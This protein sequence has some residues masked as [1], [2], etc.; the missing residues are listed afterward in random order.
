MASSTTTPPEHPKENTRPTTNGIRQNTSSS[1]STHQPPSSFSSVSSSHTQQGQPEEDKNEQQQERKSYIAWPRETGLNN[2]LNARGY[3][4]LV[5]IA[6][7]SRIYTS[8]TID[9]G[10]NFWRC[11]MTEEEA[12]RARQIPE[13][14]L[15]VLEQQPYPPSFFSNRFITR[16]SMSG[17]F[18]LLLFLCAR[19]T[20]MTPLTWEQVATI[21]QEASPEQAGD[22]FC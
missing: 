14:N 4:A 9:L 6:T 19:A 10:I 2:E 13:V 5:A 17:Y 15:I 7:A 16:T 11:Q 8:D 1:S 18:F 3:N 22:P 20:W 12:A 21:C